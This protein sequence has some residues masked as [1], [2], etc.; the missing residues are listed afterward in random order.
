MDMTPHLPGGPEA[1]AHS[2]CAPPS[3]LTAKERT[4]R[5]CCRKAA[6][7]EGDTQPQDP[8]LLC[9]AGQWSTVGHR[10]GAT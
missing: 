6:E 9:M 2:S 4:K 7:Q 8:Q 3:L 5:F 10:L 1:A